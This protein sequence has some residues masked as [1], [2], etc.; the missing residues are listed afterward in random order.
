MK[1]NPHI[2]LDGKA[3][4]VV[5][6][7]NLEAKEE[8]KSQIPF[9]QRKWDASSK[10]WKLSHT[11]ENYNKAFKILCDHFPTFRNKPLVFAKEGGV[12]AAF[13][14]S[15]DTTSFYTILG[16]RE[17]ASRDAI[18]K[19]HRKLVHK[20]HPDKNPGDKRASEMF[21]L[22]QRAF[23]TLSHEKKR[24]RYDM[25]RRLVYQKPDPF[26]SGSYGP[27]PTPRTATPGPPSPNRSWQAGD[28]IQ[29]GAGYCQLI[30]FNTYSGDFEARDVFTGFSDYISVHIF[31][32]H[33]QT[34][35]N[36]FGRRTY[37]RYLI[38]ERIRD[39]QNRRIGRVI[40]RGS[41]VHGTSWLL[42]VE[43][44]ATGNKEVVTADDVEL[45]NL[46]P[47]RPKQSSSSGTFRIGDAVNLR[48]GS[49]PSNVLISNPY[50][51]VAI[52]PQ[53]GIEIVP[54][55]GGNKLRVVAADL[56][57]VQF[58]NSPSKAPTAGF[59]VGDWVMP[60]VDTRNF[61]RGDC[62]QITA[63]LPGGYVVQKYDAFIHQRLGGRALIDKTLVEAIQSPYSQPQRPPPNLPIG[64][65]TPE[66]E[67]AQML[68]PM[69][70]LNRKT[71]PHG[72]WGVGDICQYNG[73]TVLIKGLHPISDMPIIMLPNGSEIDVPENFLGHITP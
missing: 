19:A 1:V 72:K 32:N 31:N 13:N 12:E 3:V 2:V 56:Q 40:N 51:V 15:L 54:V 44:E 20:V 29:I 63:I 48:P 37:P 36:P 43:W 46:S 21:Q 70:A 39:K 28:V 58:G 73:E 69:G 64:V 25:A 16:V 53:G 11:R 47:S 22:V 35:R 23:E 10:C 55:L 24:R 66:Q 41:D 17:D 14:A 8:L 60:T 59:K 68:I 57:I 71:S 33:A 49:T 26:Q 61:R 30:D 34:I 7:F 9:E 27:A 62:L 67:R 6:P 50:E 18:K 5:M 65:L 4:V 42:K 52:S 45:F 38:D